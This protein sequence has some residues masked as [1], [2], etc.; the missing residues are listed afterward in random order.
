MASNKVGIIGSGLIGRSWAMLFA[1]AGYDVV[2]FDIN[3]QQLDAAKQDIHDKLEELQEKHLLRG[4][5]TAEQ[6]VLLY[7]RL[8]KSKLKILT[9]FVYPLG[10][11]PS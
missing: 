11:V 8:K 5:L 3:Q 1:A 4:E 2:M 9:Q 6:Q 10:F 7:Y